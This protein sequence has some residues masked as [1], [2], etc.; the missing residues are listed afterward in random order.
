MLRT[1]LMTGIHQKSYKQWYTYASVMYGDSLNP[2][3]SGPTHPAA[4]DKTDW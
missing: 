2:T 1:H 3:C 4:L